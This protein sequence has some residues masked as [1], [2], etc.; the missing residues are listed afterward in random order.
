MWDE[1]IKYQVQSA[2][3]LDG[4]RQVSRN[5]PRNVIDVTCYREIR[6]QRNVTSGDAF[7][8]LFAAIASDLA[9]CRDVRRWQY[10][11]VSINRGGVISSR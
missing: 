1:T 2:R 7:M 6:M 5:R 3:D 4:R 10:S 11:A 8:P 9:Q